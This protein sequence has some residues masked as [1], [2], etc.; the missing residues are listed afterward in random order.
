MWD[1]LTLLGTVSSGLTGDSMGG[2][3]KQSLR[4]R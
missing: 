2:W 3:K 1:A 4:S